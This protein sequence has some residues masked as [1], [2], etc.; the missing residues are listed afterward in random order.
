MAKGHVTDQ[1]LESGIRS[2]GGLGGIAG[3]GARRDS[4]FGSD[5]ARKAVPEA[6]PEPPAAQAEAARAVEL[7]PVKE[8]AP[9]P[10]VAAS[11][12]PEVK[13]PPPVRVPAEPKPRP[14][15]PFRPVPTLP[16]IPARKSDSFTERVTLQ[17]SPD[18]RD[19]LNLLAAKLQRRKFDKS[20]RITANTIMRVAIRIVL[21]EVDFGT[22]DIAN[23]ETDLLRIVRKKLVGS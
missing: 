19:E 6:A 21:D 12:L 8:V 10:P 20:E 15:E 22:G 16:E 7:R 23:S 1:D 9:A 14:R 13:S 5:F 11:P 3:G 17:M 4:P 2:L 18:M